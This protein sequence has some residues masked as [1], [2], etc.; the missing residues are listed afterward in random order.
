MIAA[1]DDDEGKVGSEK[2]SVDSAAHWLEYGLE[3]CGRESRL[4]SYK[5]S[6]SRADCSSAVPVHKRIAGRRMEEISTLILEA[7]G[8]QSD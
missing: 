8:G 3:D 6:I 5:S 1:N 2:M 7:K 4:E